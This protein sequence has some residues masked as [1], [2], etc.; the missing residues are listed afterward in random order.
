MRFG[1]NTVFGEPAIREDKKKRETVP[2]FL[3]PVHA[4]VILKH[5]DKLML[6]A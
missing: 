3:V 1:G 5:L 4:D 6:E 2:A